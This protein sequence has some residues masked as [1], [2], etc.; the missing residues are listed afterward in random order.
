[1]SR[2]FYIMHAYAHSFIANVSR[3]FSAV[4]LLVP[5]RSGSWAFPFY[6]VSANVKERYY[7][8][9]YKFFRRFMAWTWGHLFNDFFRF[10]NMYV[11]YVLRCIFDECSFV[12]PF[13][14]LPILLMLRVFCENQVRLL[15]K[16]IC[17]CF[18]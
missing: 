18:S 13:N 9:Y 15:S 16:L 2:D 7:M 12:F 17:L 10:W 3:Q 1:M 14:F 11:L 6:N 8:T 5:F 4:R